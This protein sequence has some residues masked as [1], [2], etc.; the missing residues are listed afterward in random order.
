[1]TDQA[2]TRWQYTYDI[3][4]RWFRLSL[5]NGEEAADMGAQ[6]DEQLGDTWLAG[7]RPAMLRL[8]DGYAADAKAAGAVEA[9]VM[10]DVVEGMAV[11]SQFMVQIVERVRPDDLEA[12]LHAISAQL[13]VPRPNDLRERRVGWVDLPAGRAVHVAAV[14]EAP[15]ED[16]RGAVVLVDQYWIPVPEHRQTLV[17]GLTSPHLALEDQLGRTIA[18]IAESVSLTG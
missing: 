5:G 11:T 4:R 15:A 9:A 6:F 10:L 12:E 2:T 18:A 3:P 14:V 7:Q 17:V 16:E 13:I 8:I 1:M